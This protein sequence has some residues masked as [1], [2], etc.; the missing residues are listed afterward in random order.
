MQPVLEEEAQVVARDG[1]V[2]EGVENQRA[3]RVVA[4]RRE[5]AIEGAARGVQLAFVYVG[6]GG[7]YRLVGGGGEFGGG[8]A[9]WG[10]GIDFKLSICGR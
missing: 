10:R 8:F 4:R 2:R 7:L 9:S 5:G 1:R 3:P 6:V